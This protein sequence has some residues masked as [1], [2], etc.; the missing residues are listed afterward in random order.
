MTLVNVCKCNT[1]TILRVWF[2][3]S[4]N[5]LAKKRFTFHTHMHINIS[6]IDFD[7][8]LLI[9]RMNAH[10]LVKITNS[11]LSI[12]EVIKCMFLYDWTIFSIKLMNTTTMCLRTMCY[13]AAWDMETL[14]GFQFFLMVSLYF[15]PLFL[16]SC[17]YCHIASVLWRKSLSGSNNQ[18]SGRHIQKYGPVKILFNVCNKMKNCVK[19]HV[20][21]LRCQVCIFTSS[22]AVTNLAI[23]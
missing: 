6:A 19:Y 16:M 12:C 22:I 21:F 7:I 2:Y 8:M 11:N 13:P 18:T 10:T 15:L 9:Y 5:K 1:T 3:V 4:S 23:C 14:V 17:S 20:L